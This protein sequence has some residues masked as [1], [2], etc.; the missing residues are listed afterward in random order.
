MLGT[1]VQKILSEGGRIKGVRL[2]YGSTV[3]APWV[4]SNADFKTTLLRLIEEKAM[5]D[6]WLRWVGSARQ[7]ETTPML[8]LSSG[9]R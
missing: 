2:M 3:P 1:G 4:I 6:D 7:E 9:R 8:L 5:P